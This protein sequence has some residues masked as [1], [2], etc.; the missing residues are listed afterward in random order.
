MLSSYAVLVRNGAET[1]VPAGEVF[2]GDVVM[3]SLGDRVP[4]DLRMIEVGNLASAEA[5][6]TGESVPIDK[7]VEAID[8]EGADPKSTPFETAPTCAS[9]LH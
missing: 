3:L 6:L 2:P 8:C 5:A 7:R 9:V 4:A 1:K